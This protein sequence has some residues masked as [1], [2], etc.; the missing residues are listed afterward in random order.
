MFFKWFF[1]SLFFIIAIQRILETFSK[2]EKEKGEIRYKWTFPLFFI[3][4]FIVVIGSIVEYL[5]INREIIFIV[6]AFGLTLYLIGLIGRNWSIRT[7]GKYW[8]THIEIR[9]KH[10][11]IRNGPYKRMRHPAYLSMIFEVCGISLI[12]NAYFIFL[13]AIIVYIPFIFLMIH[14]EETEHLKT[15]GTK[16]LSYKRETG[17]FIPIRKKP[18]KT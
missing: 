16:Y 1:I 6:T 13:F 8:S 17:S 15:I 3:A 12:V 5:L 14:L 9:K 2:R 11:L 4:H 18:S 7:L 10:K